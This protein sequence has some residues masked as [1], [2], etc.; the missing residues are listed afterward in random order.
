MS[1]LDVS[2]E[3]IRRGVEHSLGEQIE[4]FGA[5]RILIY[6][7]RVPGEAFYQKLLA[8]AAA[9]R[10]GYAPT[11]AKDARGPMIHAGIT[12]RNRTWR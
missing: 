12:P 10:A 8:E 1:K 4:Q 9:E 2:Y 5:A 7:G 6:G 11:F 3:A